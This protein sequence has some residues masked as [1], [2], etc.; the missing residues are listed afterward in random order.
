LTNNERNKVLFAVRKQLTDLAGDW[1]SV[2]LFSSTN[3][4]GLE[5]AGEI[6]GGWIMQAKPETPNTNSDSELEILD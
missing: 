4:I 1:G 5:Q 2:Q 3:R 6:I